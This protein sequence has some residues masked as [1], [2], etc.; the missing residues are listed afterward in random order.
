MMELLHSVQNMKQQSQKK[1]FGFL[2]KILD[3]VL[4]LLGLVIQK[5]FFKFMQHSKP[6][7]IR[8]AVPSPLRRTFDYT[9]PQ[10]HSSESDKETLCVGARVAVHFGRRKVLTLA[11]R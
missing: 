10:A 4:Q 1:E 11:E 6:T 3:V 7:I 8:V 9:L 5:E 2:I